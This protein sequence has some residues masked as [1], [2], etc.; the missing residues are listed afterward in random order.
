MLSRNSLRQASTLASNSVDG[1]GYN[2]GGGF[3]YRLN[4]V[5]HAKVYVEGRY[6]HANTKD[7]RTTVFPVTVG[8]RW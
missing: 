3:T 7:G 2:F 8:L 1:G 4:K 6:H 5:M